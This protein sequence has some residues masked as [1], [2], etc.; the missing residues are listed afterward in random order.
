M[1]H[2]EYF[3]CLKILCV[4]PIHPS[5]LQFMTKKKMILLLS[6]YFLLF[7]EC[8]IFRIIQYVAFTIW[9][10][11]YSNMHFRFLHVFS[12]LDKLFIFNTDKY[13]IVWKYHDLFIC[14]PTKEHHSCFRIL[15]ITKKAAIKICVQVLYEH[16]FIFF[17]E[18]P[19]G[20]CWYITCEKY[21]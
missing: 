18:I 9:L 15:A 14:S 17:G 20:S 16:V 6:P 2:T 4:P 5:P 13:S 21:V 7:K 10:L 1:I 19:K 11:S 12:W 3:H 8:Y